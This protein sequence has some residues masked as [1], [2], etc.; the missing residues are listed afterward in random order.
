MTLPLFTTLTQV[1][2][3]TIYNDDVRYK[4]IEI[5]HDVVQVILFN[6]LQNIPS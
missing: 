1:T 4:L 3:S 5:I 2:K 6:T